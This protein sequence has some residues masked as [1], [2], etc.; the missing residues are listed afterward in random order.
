M[1]KLVSLLLSALLVL[2]M[3]PAMAQGIGT[4]E[5]PVTVLFQNKDVDVN[6]D[7][8]IACAKLIEE[9][10]AAQGDYIK[11]VELESPAGTYGD[12]VPL[13]LRTGQLQADIVYF[14]GGDEAVAQE[15]LLED[16]T[17]YIEHS[18]Y[19]KEAMA[20][21]NAARTANYPYLLWLSPATV[22]IP[23]MREDHLTQVGML[24]TLVQEPTV[25]NYHK[26]LK[27]LVDQGIVKYAISGDGSL[28]RLNHIFNHAFGVTSTLMKAQSG[29][30]VYSFATEAEKN[31]LAFYAQ[32]Y[33]E[34][35]ID[36]DF[37]T[38][39]WAD[40][41]QK[42]YGGELALVAVTQG[43]VVDSYATRIVENQGEGAKA[44]MLPPA[45]GI[46]QRYISV[47]VAKETRGMAINA[48]S[49]VKEAAFAVMDFL[50][51]PAGRVID[52]LGAQGITYE[53]QDGKAIVNENLRTYYG[54]MWETYAN[55]SPDVVDFGTLMNAQG[56]Q[57]MDMAHQYYAEDVDVVLPG[58]LLPTYDAIREIYTQ[59]ATDIILGVRPVEAFDEFVAQYPALGGDQL[60]EY[61]A[62]V[63]N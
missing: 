54:M 41:A 29:K 51:S 16:L 3:A 23:M 50:A 35:L 18:Q 22:Y 39:K 32:L 42:F 36:P 37:L 48:A 24:E 14:Q 61:L 47:T 63:L 49:P 30:W 26:A 53:M 15:G 31:K 27:A 7:I 43:M 12:A 21:H 25:E 6:A 4:P 34:G 57:S 2:T 45:S 8:I 44:I 55:L 19:V 52:K 13:A 11:L 40:V 5:N 62:T 33:A 56:W 1:K 38:A 60:S 58:D 17:P 9:Q 59:Y 46:S 10:M 20:P 28:N